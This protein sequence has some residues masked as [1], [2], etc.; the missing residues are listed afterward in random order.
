MN[1]TQKVTEYVNN[2]KPEQQSD[3]NEPMN[4]QQKIEQDYNDIKDTLTQDIRDKIETIY[5]ESTKYS[6]YCL[7][8]FLCL[9]LTPYLRH[10]LQPDLQAEHSVNFTNI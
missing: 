9:C 7:S 8:L 3:E 4:I 2:K 5:S 6:V 10:P 1:V